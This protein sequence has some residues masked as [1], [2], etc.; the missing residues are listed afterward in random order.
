MR[1]GC[2]TDLRYPCKLN[3]RF[4]NPN[5]PD[6]TADYILGILIEANR[7]KVESAIQSSAAEQLSEEGRSR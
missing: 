1:G 3:Y 2:H 4:H 5:P 7:K 6:M